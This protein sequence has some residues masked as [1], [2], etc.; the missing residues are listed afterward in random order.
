NARIG[1]KI[2]ASVT[3]RYCPPTSE[4]ARVLATDEETYDFQNSILGI[5][6]MHEEGYTGKG[7]T[8]A[9]FDAGFPGANT[10][11]PLVHL[12]TNGQI[13]GT[14]DLVRPWNDNVYSDNQHGTNVLSLIA[15]DEP[16]KMVAGAP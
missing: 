10:A 6:K 3:N 13:I 8:V 4:S 7:V 12:Q 11:S 9:V 15:S 5:D 2:Y 1:S 16:G 14:K